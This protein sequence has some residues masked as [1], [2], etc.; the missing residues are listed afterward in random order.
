MAILVTGGGGY[1]GSVLVQVLRE[2]GIAVVVVDNLS[3]GHR[4]A[5]AKVLLLFGRERPIGLDE[6]SLGDVG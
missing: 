6:I 5:V 4:E 2:R 1:I 3:R